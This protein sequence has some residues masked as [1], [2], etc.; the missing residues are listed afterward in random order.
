MSRPIEGAAVCDANIL[1]DLA[2]VDE[3]IIRQMAHCWKAVY[4]PDVVLHEVKALSEKKAKELGLIIIETPLDLPRNPRLSF[5]DR[6]CLY[7]VQKEQWVCLT[8]DKVLRIT[9]Q[10]AGG[11]VIW[12][13]ELLLI[14]V[15]VKV[16]SPQRA[17]TAAR[18]IHSI[19]QA[20]TTS[21]L[22]DFEKKLSLT[23]HS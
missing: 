15:K 18:K 4:I 16:I 3:G 13:L 9:C 12:G 2:A 8:N 11:Q 5:Q 17:P 21:L 7:F 10:E 23:T 22:L 19:N 14:L 20:I 6:A 1:I